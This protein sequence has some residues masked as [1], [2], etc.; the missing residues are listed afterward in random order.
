MDGFFSFLGKLTIILIIVGVLLG[1]GY[2][3]GTGKL[4]FP[5]SPA[6]GAVTTTAPTGQSSPG[7]A[8]PLTTPVLTNT[9]AA[10]PS[11]QTV[12][13]DRVSG[14]SF[15]SFTISVPT[16]WTVKKEITAGA[17]A[18]VTISRGN[19]SMGIYQAATG[20]AQCVYPGEAQAEMSTAFGPFVTLHD[21]SGNEFRRATPAGSASGFTVCQKSNGLFGLPTNYGHVTYGTPVS[22][23]PGVL[24]E[25]DAIFATLKKT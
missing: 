17:S 12:S 19:Y 7:G 2:Y 25:M 10:S 5:M 21:A 9:P 3:L 6:P 4:P 14:T 22:P 13:V 1:G 20:G 24:Q 23:D 8:L 11:S 18:R 16:T 15:G